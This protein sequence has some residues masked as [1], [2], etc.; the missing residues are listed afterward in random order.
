MKRAVLTC[1]LA[2]SWIL[3]LGQKPNTNHCHK[4]RTEENVIDGKK[5]TS[6]SGL[7]YTLSFAQF[8]R[9]VDGADTTF[10]LMASWNESWH[11]LD[12]GLILILDDGT[13]LE[14]PDAAHTATLTQ[15][16]MWSHVGLT[17]IP[18]EDLQAFTRSG[19]KAF[20]I[21]KVDAEIPGTAGKAI[22]MTNAYCLTNS[23]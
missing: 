18:G 23:K 6:M 1:L 8:F 15:Q 10:V 20:R 9:E 2:M 7:K 13:R 3:L 21:G 17:S 14:Y 19:I 22:P 11:N 4:L 12:R 5:T 16:G